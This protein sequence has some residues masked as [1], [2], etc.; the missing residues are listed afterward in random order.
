MRSTASSLIYLAAPLLLALADALPHDDHHSTGMD[1][2][3]GGGTDSGHMGSAPSNHTADPDDQDHLM[4][5]FAYQKHSGMIMAH[6]VIMVLAWFFTLPIGVM[7]SIARSRLALPTQF[8]FLILN[9]LGLLI[10]II[11]NSQTPDLYE[12]N[13][14]HKI[15]WIATWAM[16]AQTVMGMILAYSGRGRKDQ[17]SPHER[18]SFLPSTMNGHGGPYPT[19]PMH[20]YRWSGDSGQGT[21]RASSSISSPMSPTSGLRI[22]D[23]DEF[24]RYGKPEGELADEVTGN[25][26]RNSIIDRIFSRRLSGLVSGRGISIISAVYG[27]IDRLILFLGFIAI[28]SGGVVYGGIFRGNNVF[29]GLAHFI[30]GGIFFW[31]GLLTFGRWMGCFADF[32]WAWNLKPSRDHVGKFKAWVPSGEFT[33]SFVIFLY[34]ST[35]VFLEHL[36]AWGLEWSAQDLEHVAISVMFF[37]GGLC[38]MLIESERVRNWLN[39][40]VLKPSGRVELHGPDAAAWQPPRSQRSSLNPIPALVIMLLGMMMSSHHQDSMVSTMVHGQWG[41]LLVAFALARAV[42]YILLYINPPTSLYPSRP[43][44]E[45]ITSFCLVSG[46]LIFMLSTKDVIA[47]MEYYN[48]N[49]MFTFTVGMGF[50]A[51]IMAWELIVVAVKAWAIKRQQPPSLETYQF[52]T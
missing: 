42:T 16:I 43:P 46:G 3:M 15:G 33:E 4:S 28:V 5:Y 29:N 37:G 9:S 41:M 35:N 13:A 32:G 1:M 2:N 31:Y 44:S 21:E 20:E 18:A 8:L 48:L 26:R 14:H 49:A 6:I 36:A 30:K 7:F 23:P 45:I 51:F 34:G 11:Y 17:G 25:S 52:P 39:D 50:T 24:D 22:T 40:T 27:T 47:A 12:N 38:G 19:G 10:G